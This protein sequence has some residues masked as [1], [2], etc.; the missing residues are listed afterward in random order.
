MGVSPLN[1]LFN[2]FKKGRNRAAFQG[3]MHCPLC[4][5]H[6]DPTTSPIGFES[7]KDK[8]V[9][10]ENLG[11]FIRVYKCMHCGGEWRYDIAKQQ[12]HPYSSFKRGLKLP[13]LGYSGSVPLLK[14]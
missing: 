12:T 7:D 9:L 6:V 13:G 3:N 8:I 1:M 4:S 10:K 2:P 5:K 14:K 11:P